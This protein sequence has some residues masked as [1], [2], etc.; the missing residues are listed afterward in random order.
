MSQADST[1]A[2]PVQGA[3][4][5]LLETQYTSL[6]ELGASL[7][8]SE[9]H[10][11][12][13]LPGWSV[14]DIYAHII[15]TEAMME[16]REPPDVNVDVERL[17]HV[18]NDVGVI[19]E[20]WIE[21]LSNLTPEEMVQQYRETIAA[22]M[23]SLRSLSAEAFNEATMTPVGLAPYWRYLQIRVFD[24]W[25][26]EQDVRES[27]IRPGN[28]SGRCAEAAVDEVE[29]SIG[30]LIGKKADAPSGS[31]V[32]IE[33]TGPVYRTI[34]VE[35][36]DRAQQVERLE[37]PPTSRVI[38]TSSLFMR[39]IGGR[40]DALASRLGAL[41]FEGDLGLARQIVGNLAFTL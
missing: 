30:F 37:G 3:L 26:H 21:A 18:R 13:S 6:E 2:A 39:L 9:W 7:T 28:E 17:A 29:R 10:Q 33:L 34:H 38:L 16:G 35:V 40:T 1:V 8:P 11:R 27:L 41:E 14:F 4:I 19:N 32:T 5:D 20:T 24:C 25:M 22:R 31:T 36:L 15:G 23:R 12:A